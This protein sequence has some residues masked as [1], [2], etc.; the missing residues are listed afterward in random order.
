M[1]GREALLSDRVACERLP[2]TPWL[3]AAAIP[4]EGSLLAVGAPASQCATILRQRTASRPRCC[5]LVRGS[6][7]AP[8]RLGGAGAGPPRARAARRR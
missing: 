1:R 2:A 4:P 7:G 3:V 8:P 5:G 6:R